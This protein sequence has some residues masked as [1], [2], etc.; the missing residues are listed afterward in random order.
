MEQNANW[1]EITPQMLDAGIA[2]LRRWR[3]KD[4]EP[5]GLV[6]AVYHTMRMAALEREQIK[7]ANAESH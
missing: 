6:A 7:E 1:I 3:Y 5:E 2:A 4:E